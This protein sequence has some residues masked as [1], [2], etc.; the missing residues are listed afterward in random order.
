MHKFSKFL[1][2]NNFYIIKHLYYI[3]YKTECTKELNLQNNH[4]NMQYLAH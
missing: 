1:Y 4:V 3:Q 2:I